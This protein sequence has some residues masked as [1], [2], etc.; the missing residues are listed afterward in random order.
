MYSL[1]GMKVTMRIIALLLC[2]ILILGI[3][4]CFLS[5]GGNTVTK[6]KWIIRLDPETGEPY[7]ECIPTN[8]PPYD[9]YIGSASIR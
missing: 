5:G 6:G 4:G 7:G 8:R 3:V 2:V 1:L 9:C